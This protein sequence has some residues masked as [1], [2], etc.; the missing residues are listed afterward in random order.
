MIEIEH[1]FL[2]KNDAWKASASEGVRYRQGYIDTVNGTTVRVRIAGDQGY[3][4]L[5]GK[6]GGDAGISCSEFEYEI[7]L[8]DAEGMIEEFLDTPLIDKHRYLVEYHGKIW[9][10]DV[11]VGDNEGLEV[12]EI[13]LGSE[14]EAFDL[15][16]WAGECVSGDCRYTNG[17]LAKLPFK[18]W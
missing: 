1:K 14:D 17:S 10:I 11:F 15:P 2:L 4:T 3:L 12:A 18:D 16:S 5:K 8:E 7:P 6:R 13:E 9:E